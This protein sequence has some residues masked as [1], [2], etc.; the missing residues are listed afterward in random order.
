MI[1]N[2][3]NV[4]FF[5]FANS[6]SGKIIASHLKMKYKN[7]KLTKVIKRLAG[8]LS[9][10]SEELEK[11]IVSDLKPTPPFLRVPNRLRVYLETEKE[12]KKIVEE[13]LDTYSTVEEDY[14]RQLLNPAFERAAGNLLGN[15]ENDKAFDEL[16]SLH[17]KE[18]RNI[19]YKVAYKYKLPTI[20]ITPFC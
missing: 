18:Y 11:F 14:K 19:Y 12:L 7:K 5:L 13:K 1:R 6:Y 17:V 4:R 10:N 3:E 8:I 16:I 9:L 15:V 20:R 2:Y